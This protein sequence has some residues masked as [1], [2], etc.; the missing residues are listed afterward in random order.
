MDFD[1]SAEYYGKKAAKLVNEG[2]ITTKQ[3]L[4]EYRKN[5][6]RDSIGTLHSP[7]NKNDWVAIFEKSLKSENL[8]LGKVESK[9]EAMPYRQLHGLT[10]QEVYSFARNQGEQVAQNIRNGAY[11]SHESI[12]KTRDDIIKKY[13]PDFMVEVFKK[14]FEF[15]LR[16]SLT[17]TPQAATKK[18]EYDMRMEKNKKKMNEKLSGQK[19][20][21]KHQR[22]WDIKGA[23]EAGAKDGEEIAKLYFKGIV[24]T[25]QEI[26]KALHE[27]FAKT[28]LP[29]TVKNHYAKAYLTDFDKTLTN[30]KQASIEGMKQAIKSNEG[31]DL[32]VGQQFTIKNE[33]PQLTR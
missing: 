9:S 23:Y 26:T 25:Q 33:S 15:G 18:L 16:D 3:Q 7:D 5:T 31:R 28:G 6:M 4:S 8:R 29:E 10:M 11:K 1:Q 22:D 32:K 19:L 13:I 21:P 14:A 17:K 20:S 30:M 24:Q 27:D 2:E 12:I